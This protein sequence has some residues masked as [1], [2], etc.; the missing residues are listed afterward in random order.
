MMKEGMELFMEPMVMLSLFAGGYVVKSLTAVKKGFD[1]LMW[2][3][4]GVFALIIATLVTRGSP[5]S[6]E[7]YVL[8]GLIIFGFAVTCLLYRNLL[9]RVNEHS[10][11]ILSLLVFYCVTKYVRV[12]DSYI[13]IAIV[14]LFAGLPLLLSL[15]SSLVNTPIH[16]AFKL[17]FYIWFII[18]NIFFLIFY[19]VSYDISLTNFSVHRFVSPFDAFLTGF[20]AFTLLS[21]L[22]FLYMFVFPGSRGHGWKGRINEWKEYATILVQKHD[23]SQLHLYQTALILLIGGGGLIV[24]YLFGSVSDGVV[25][26]VY[27]LFSQSLIPPNH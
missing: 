3:T 1:M 6:I 21:N 11:L 15:Y 23:D 22:G 19:L 26:P 14:F 20:T 8:F 5:T 18:V 25:I 4:S 2:I 16:S 17:F 13:G 10:L 9:P 7:T 27:L 24:N 12:G